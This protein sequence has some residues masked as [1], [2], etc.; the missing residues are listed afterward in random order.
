MSDTSKTALVAANNYS[1]GF[2]QSTSNA[3]REMFGMTQVNYL[4]ISYSRYG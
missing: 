1:A 4:R 2:G 3:F